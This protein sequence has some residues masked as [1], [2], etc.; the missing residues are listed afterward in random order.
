LNW[1]PPAFFAVF[2]PFFLAGFSI[3]VNVFNNLVLGI[4]SNNSN[5]M[6]AS[7]SRAGCSSTK[8]KHINE[9]S[10]MAT[11]VSSRQR[12]QIQSLIRLGDPKNISMAKEDTGL[13]KNRQLFTVIEAFYS[14]LCDLP[15]E[16][17]IN[18]G[19]PE[20][21]IAEQEETLRSL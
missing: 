2:L 13:V 19:G 4:L 5:P 14:T 15:L 6:K 9:K 8:L 21:W 18:A 17:L 11:G 7:V 12:S 3:R 10:E 20:V 1:G 16:K